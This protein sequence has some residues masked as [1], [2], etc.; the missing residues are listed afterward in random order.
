MRAR[1]FRFVF[2]RFTGGANYRFPDSEL[3]SGS[4]IRSEGHFVS[5]ICTGSNYSNCTDLGPSMMYNWGLET[6]TFHFEL[7]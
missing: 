5:G 2:V 3:I 1:L 4:Q 6:V 7:Y